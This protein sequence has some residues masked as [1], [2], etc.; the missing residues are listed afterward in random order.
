MQGGFGRVVA[1]LL[2]RPDDY[3]SGDRDAGLMGERIE[4]VDN[5]HVSAGRRGK[6]RNGAPDAMPRAL[7]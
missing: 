3:E 6:L 4:N 7:H 2:L 1:R 5:D